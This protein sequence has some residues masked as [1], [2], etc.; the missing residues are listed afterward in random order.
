MGTAKNTTAN[1]TA[2]SSASALADS[3]TARHSH[4]SWWERW[5]TTSDRES[6]TTVARVP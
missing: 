4:P 2:A 5:E 6:S 1:G 3:A